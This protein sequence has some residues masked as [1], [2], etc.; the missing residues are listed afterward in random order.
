[1][2]GVPAAGQCTD[3]WRADGATLP[4]GLF[5]RHRTEGDPLPSTSPDSKRPLHL[6]RDRPLTGDKVGGDF[7]YGA[8]TSPKTLPS[9]Q[10]QGSSA[11][12]QTAAPIQPHH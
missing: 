12:W 9:G 11:A 6:M 4:D 10:H 7:Y 5:S 8:P 1:G 3:S 2:G